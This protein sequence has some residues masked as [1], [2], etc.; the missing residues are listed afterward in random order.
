MAQTKAHPRT[1]R[2][3]ALIFSRDEYR[4]RLRRVREILTDREIDLLYVTSPPNLFYLT[5]YELIW[6]DECPVSGLALRQDSDEFL[7]FD[8]KSHQEQIVQETIVSEGVFLDPER[9][10]EQAIDELASR[11]LLKGTVGFEDWSWTPSAVSERSRAD[12]SRPAR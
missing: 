9:G 10:L 6:Y 1:A 12:S 7:L 4:E 8:A 3:E 2:D 11:G 5:G